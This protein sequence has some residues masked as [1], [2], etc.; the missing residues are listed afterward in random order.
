MVEARRQGDLLELDTQY[1]QDDHWELDLYG[2]GTMSVLLALAGW[3]LVRSEAHWAKRHYSSDMGD[4]EGLAY[5]IGIF[6]EVARDY[7]WSVETTQVR[8]LERWQ[9]W[10]RGE[11]FGEEQQ[12]RDLKTCASRPRLEGGRG[13][14]REA[15]AGGPVLLHRAAPEPRGDERVLRGLARRGD[16]D[17]QPIRLFVG[18]KSS[19]PEWW[20]PT[21]NVVAD[22]GRPPEARPRGHRAGGA[23]PRAVPTLLSLPA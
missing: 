12:L 6:E 15:A 17:A 7:G 5:K 23:S 11:D 3:P 14:P 8:G 21:M 18:R 19:T 16:T 10:A 4:P 2:V 9:A 13:A 1:R 22:E 20:G